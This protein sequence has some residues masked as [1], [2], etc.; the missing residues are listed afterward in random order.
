MVNFYKGVAGARGRN[1]KGLVY[2]NDAG[3]RYANAA[4][5]SSWL[6]T[7]PAELGFAHEYVCSDGTYHAEDYGNMAWHTANSDGNA[8]YIGIEICQSMGGLNTFLSNEQKAFQLG[9]SILKMYGLPANRNTIKLHKQFFATACPHRSV[10]Q[11][12]DWEA[13]Q[14]YFIAQTQKYMNGS[15]AP[16]PTP[17]PPNNGGSNSGNNGSKPNSIILE[18]NEMRLFYTVDGKAPVRYFDG[19]QVRNLAHPDEQKVLNDIY[20]AN[21]GKNIPNMNFS[22]KAP[23]YRRLLD[24]INRAPEK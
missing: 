24:A 19:Q 18:E 13:C 21:T 22:S 20:K 1:P 6:P 14:D 7:H 11:H 2:H 16:T 17:T 10:E 3:S 23:Y 5:Y 9:A 12:G 4:Y 15:P 8:N